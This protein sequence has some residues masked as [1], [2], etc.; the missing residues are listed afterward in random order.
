MIWAGYKSVML[1]LYWHNSSRPVLVHNFK[2]IALSFLQVEMFS[3]QK[4][5]LANKS[6]IDI[7][8]RKTK[9]VQSCNFH[10]TSHPNRE[11]VP[12]LGPTHR[13]D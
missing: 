6:D 3:F 7:L 1:L 13:H 9:R 10:F 8:I 5:T 4:Q 2:T 12:W 11:F